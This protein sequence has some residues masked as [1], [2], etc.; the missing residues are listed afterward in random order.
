VAFRKQGLFQTHS[1][2]HTPLYCISPA[3][4]NSN[5]LCSNLGIEMRLLRFLCV[6]ILVCVLL[7]RSLTRWQRQ[8]CAQFG[9]GRYFIPG[10]PQHSF[11]FLGDPRFGASLSVI[12]S[13]LRSVLRAHCV[14]NQT[15]QMRVG[16]CCYN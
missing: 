8:H 4:G 5:T 16:V 15:A 3:G 9:N 12:N 11:N 2:P 6:F 1:S 14:H 13:I 10:P 7:L